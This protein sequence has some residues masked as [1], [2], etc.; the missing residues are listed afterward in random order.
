MSYG[1]V[2][3]ANARVPVEQEPWCNIIKFLQVSAL[4]TSEYQDF[5]FDALLSELKIANLYL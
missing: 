4:E 3:R 5:R 1:F 2:N